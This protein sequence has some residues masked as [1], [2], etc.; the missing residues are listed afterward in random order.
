MDA[1]HERALLM[2]GWAGTSLLARKG[3]EPGTMLSWSLFAVR[4]AYSSKTFMQIA[5]LEKGC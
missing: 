5:T 2:A 1:C 3:N 4:A